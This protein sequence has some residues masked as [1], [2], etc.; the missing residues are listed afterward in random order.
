MRETRKNSAFTHVNLDNRFACIDLALRA[1]RGW[2]NQAAC[3]E[4]ESSEVIAPGVHSSPTVRTRADALMCLKGQEIQ[5]SADDRKGGDPS[6][7]GKNGSIDAQTQY[8]RRGRLVEFCHACIKSKLGL[9][10][11]HVRGLAKVQMEPLWACLTYNLQQWFRLSKP[12][13]PL[14]PAKERNQTDRR[15]HFSIDLPGTAKRSRIALLA[16]VSPG[17]FTASFVK[18]RAPQIQNKGRATR[19]TPQELR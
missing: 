9:R 14:P 11:F 8:R 7:P 19:H 3:C 18:D 6:P 16:P 4:G 5:P 1:H 10:K 15:P 12:K 13:R 17:F 2:R